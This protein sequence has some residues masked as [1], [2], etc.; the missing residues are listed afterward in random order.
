MAQLQKQSDKFLAGVAVNR[1]TDMKTRE[2]LVAEYEA[3]IQELEADLRYVKN[4]ADEPLKKE[5][6]KVER[7]RLMSEN[8]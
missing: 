3:R 7:D 5:A 2:G 1:A 6:D 8:E 4:R